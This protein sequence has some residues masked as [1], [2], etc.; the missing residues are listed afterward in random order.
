MV[1]T[2]LVECITGRYFEKDCKIVI[3]IDSNASLLDLHYAIQDAVGFEQD[4]LFVFFAGRNARD[5]EILFGVDLEDGD[6]L[7]ALSD[8]TLAKVYPLP[9]GLSLFYRFDFGDNWNFK[10]RK[11]RKNPTEPVEGVDYPRVVGRVGPNPIQYPRCK[12]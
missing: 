4:H 6:P 12:Q 5:R 9:K 1:W 10:V 3:E 11:I 8:T 2:F 7:V